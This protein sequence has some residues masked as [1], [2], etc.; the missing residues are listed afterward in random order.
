MDFEREL[1][2]DP[3]D[4]FTRWMEDARAS[5]GQSN[6]HSMTLCTVGE[7]GLPQGRV[8]LLKG[9]DS[10]G[11]RFFT[12]S[13]SEKGRALAAHPWAEA[14]F[15]WDALERQ[16][17]VRGRVSPLRP[18]ETRAYFL[19]RPRDSRISAWASDQSA[20]VSGRP[21][22]ERRFQE[23]AAR[24][25]EGEVGP[26]PP[27]WGYLLSPERFEFWRA[28]GARFHDRVRF[29]LGEGLW[30]AQRLFP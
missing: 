6:P 11:L 17:R 28:G 5:S 30:R 9:W 21:E 22:M 1:G 19:T 16:L 14:V 3:W 29:S 27:W 8:L 26:P 7:D 12:N 15:H 20:P 13:A 4:A 10:R 18:D 23:A 24:F 2:G 25:G